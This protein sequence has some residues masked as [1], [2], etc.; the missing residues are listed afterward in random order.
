ML[1]FAQFLPPQK[2]YE[3]N[4]IALSIFPRIS[5]FQFHSALIISIANPT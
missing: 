5:S 2:V 3:C 1:Q 4:E